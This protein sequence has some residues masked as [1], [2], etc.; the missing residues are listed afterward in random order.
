MAL[1]QGAPVG[2]KN[3]A[4]AK[5]WEGA[6]R[7]AL[8]QYQDDKIKQGHALRMIAETVVL[9]AVAGDKDAWKEIG[10]RLDGKAVQPIAGEIDTN[11]TV[12]V[13]RFGNTAP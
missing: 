12:K 10:D 5:A 6:L 3:A 8:A 2:N 11:I 4:K 13:V 7:A 9:R 1:K